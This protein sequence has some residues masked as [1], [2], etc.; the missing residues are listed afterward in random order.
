MLLE[1]RC[2]DERD[3]GTARHDRGY[4][5]RWLSIQLNEKIPNQNFLGWLD[6]L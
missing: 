1:S 5:D 4:A 2:E 6:V 3:D